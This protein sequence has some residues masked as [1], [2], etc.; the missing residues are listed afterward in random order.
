MDYVIKRRNFLTATA[1]SITGG[2]TLAAPKFA[3]GAN[4]DDTTA[5][6]AAANQFLQDLDNL[7]WE[8]FQ[9]SWAAEPS[10]FFPFND[11]PERVDGKNAVDERFKLFFDQVKEKVPGPPYL[12]LTP[13]NLKITRYGDA[14]LVTFTLGGLSSV[15]G[16][17]GSIGRRTILFVL[18]DN[19]WKV[20]HL[21]ASSAG[22]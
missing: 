15:G 7:D 5:L 11:T 20:A 18:Q 6:Q 8:P 10:V 3:L 22:S 21:H 13:N 12:K 16:L 17:S 9:K 4:S 1:L 2:V 19:K 14:G